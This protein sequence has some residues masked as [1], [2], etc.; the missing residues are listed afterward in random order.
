MK[1]FK[2]K[3]NLTRVDLGKLRLW[4]SYETIIALQTQNNDVIISENIWSKTTGRHINII[5]E[6]YKHLQVDTKTFQEQVDK[7][8]ER[9]YVNFK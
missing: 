9:L 3:D 7:L 1:L 2:L 6:G 5:K 4:F 8:K